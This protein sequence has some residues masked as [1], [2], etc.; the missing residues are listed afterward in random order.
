MF[1]RLLVF[2][3]LLLLGI[4]YRL[5]LWRSL[6]D[7]WRRV[8]RISLFVVIWALVSFSE[9]I[10]GWIGNIK[11]VQE[12]PLYQESEKRFGGPAGDWIQQKLHTLL[13]IHL[14]VWLSFGIVMTAIAAVLTIDSRRIFAIGVGRLRDKVPE[15]RRATK[16]NVEA[17]ALLEFLDTGKTHG[18]GAIY[19]LLINYWKVHGDARLPL[20]RVLGTESEVLPVIQL[21]LP[22]SVEAN[23]S[24]IPIER[25]LD[26]LIKV[27][28]SLKDAWPEP[29]KRRFPWTKRYGWS[30]PRY[31]TRFR[32]PTSAETTFRGDFEGYNVCLREAKIGERSVQ[33]PFDASLQQYGYIMDTCDAMMSELYLFGAMRSAARR[34]LY[35]SRS[36][37]SG[38]E[39]AADFLAFLPLRRRVMLPKESGAKA[40]SGILKP[41]DRAAA[42]GVSALVVFREEQFDGSTRL[43]ALF[44][45]RSSSVGTYKRTRHVVPAGMTN[46][47]PPTLDPENRDRG[48]QS[49]EGYFRVSSMIQREFLEEL[50]EHQWTQGTQMKGTTPWVKVAADECKEFMEGEDGKYRT[51]IYLTGVVVDLLNCRPE[52]CALIL[53]DDPSWW[54]TFEIRPV[55]GDYKK[56]IQVNFEGHKDLKYADVLNDA[57]VK[58]AFPIDNSVMSG[59]AAFHLGVSKVRA[60]VAAGE[61][62]LPTAKPRTPE[63]EKIPDAKEADP[64]AA[65]KAKVSISPRPKAGSKKPAEKPAKTGSRKGPKTDPS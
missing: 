36:S 4:R 12:L 2:W 32:G 25:A 39:S 51:Q 24:R 15:H 48:L 46:F 9:K 1:L 65:K 30:D 40:A 3:E 31:L 59:A 13:G 8:K 50:F 22:D 47:R 55:G 23:G 20:V 38:A 49:E 27:D 18:K 41:E 26:Y 64:P 62:E 63:S 61:I 29:P 16:D 42:F 28:V 17:E 60:L 21:P 7:S 53:I 10:A 56:H 58:A 14:P 52:V 11:T 43:L 35:Q 54:E 37:E 57:E 33:L 34:L 45:E 5:R 44:V 19:R 6:V